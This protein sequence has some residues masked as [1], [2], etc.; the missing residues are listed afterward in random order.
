MVKVAKELWYRETRNFAIFGRVSWQ[1]SLSNDSLKPTNH[2]CLFHI[3]ED[4]FGKQFS[5]LDVATQ[6]PTLEI[7]IRK[8]EN[9]YRNYCEFAN[10]FT[11]NHDFAPPF[12][13]QLESP[14]G[15]A[16]IRS[17]FVSQCNHEVDKMLF[18]RFEIASR[19]AAPPLPLR[20]NCE[21]SRRKSLVDFN[22]RS[23]C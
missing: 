23:P 10:L 4:I 14:L 6:I 18:R 3:A 16:A 15:R 9:D 12:N 20:C 5:A 1:S 2:Q 21:R 11:P 7:Q 19:P 13:L 17:T 8:N 22:S